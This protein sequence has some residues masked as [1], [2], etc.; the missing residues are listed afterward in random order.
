MS[1]FDNSYELPDADTDVDTDAEDHLLR[2]PQTSVTQQAE[3]FARIQAKLIPKAADSQAAEL[4]DSK[5]RVYFP[6]WGK[7]LH[8]TLSTAAQD[9][10]V[11]VDCEREE[12]LKRLGN[13]MGEDADSPSKYCH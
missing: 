1:F 7:K 9:K 13:M 4:L 12:L 5:L 3:A 2:A 10:T 6:T 8:N 11:S